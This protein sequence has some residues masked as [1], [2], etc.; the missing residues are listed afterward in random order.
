M[1]TPC[2]A[3]EIRPAGDDA[4]GADTACTQKQ[5]TCDIENGNASV[6]VDC[7]T[8]GATKCAFKIREDLFTAV[9]YHPVVLRDAGLGRES[10]DVDADSV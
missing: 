9:Q 6:G 4:S 8:Q 7:P 5:C 2:P 1:C 3:G 10:G